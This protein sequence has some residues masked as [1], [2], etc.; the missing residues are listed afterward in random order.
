MSSQQPV[1]VYD[2]DHTIYDGDVSVDFIVFCLR[3]QPTLWK[4]LPGQALAFMHYILGTW[5]RTHVKQVAFA[6]LRGIPDVDAAVAS[7]WQS[8]THKIAS[9]YAAQH[10]E[11]DVVISASPEF[12][13]YPIARTLGIRTVL[14]TE[15]DPATGMIAG[16]NCRGP[17]KLRRLR[18]LNPTVHIGDCYSDSLSD[19]PLF[20]AAARAFVVT[21]G[22]RVPL[23]DYRPK[24]RSLYDPAF[25]RFL[26]VGGINAAL[27]IIFSYGIALLIGNPLLAYALG[28]ATSLVISYFLNAA[29]T[30]KDVSFSLAQFVR[31]CV[32]Y[33][34]N[35][36]IV[37]IAVYVFAD[38]LGLY[39]LVAYI[40]AAAIAA[41]VTFLLL[42]NFTFTRGAS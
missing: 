3:R 40:L 34:P 8:H 1:T 28:Y 39:S 15:M 35:F 22:H 24:L 7:F 30:F 20:D 33:I 27:G 38:V 25:I 14:A 10:Q 26:L 12:L 36:V 37:F 16:K 11:S 9:W 4:Y 21:K 2:F 23:A 31:F 5:N 42:S 19:K 17:E 13:L 41:P 6:F 18:A 29:I 32:S